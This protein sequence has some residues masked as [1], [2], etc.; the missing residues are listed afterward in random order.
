MRIKIESVVEEIVSNK[1]VVGI[2]Q[3]ADKV[4]F[5]DEWRDALDQRLVEWV[6]QADFVPV[7]IPNNL[8]DIDSSNNHHHKIDKW[9]ISVK[10]DALL[11]SGGNDIGDVENR[12]LTEKYLLSWAEK[13]K[14]PALGICRGMQMMGVYAG[15][16]L[17]G[18]DGHVGTF[19]RLQMNNKN[20]QALPVTVNSY[21]NLA[22]ESCPDRFD[23][24]TKSEDGNLEA[25]K[26][27]ELPWEGWMWHPER[28]EQFSEIDQERFITLMNSG[29]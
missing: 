24:L 1:I 14:K 12:D 2:T 27:K 22:L 5:Y 6:A 19:H 26:H 16:K 4:K 28:E 25:I 21:H 17:I 23:I 11:L 20:T 15:G 18:V 29:K 13:N 8:I 9:L 3:R 7:P 10:V